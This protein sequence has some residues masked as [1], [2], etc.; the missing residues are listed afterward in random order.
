MKFTDLIMAI[1]T[2]GLL[3]SGWYMSNRAVDGPDWDGRLQGL[4]FSPYHYDQSPIDGYEPSLAQIEADLALLSSR[5]AAVR[6]YSTTGVLREVPRIAGKFG[7][8]VMAGAWI[9]DGPAR[10]SMELD[11]LLA[12]DRE[13]PNVDRLIVGNEAL[14]REE[15]DVPTLISYL[16]RVQTATNTPVSTS[17][18]WHVWIKHPELAAHVDFIAV[19]ILPFWEGVPVDSAL[20]HIMLRYEELR[21]A[22]P[23]KRIVLTEIG[24][25]SDGLQRGQAV[26]SLANQAWLI[27]NFLIEAKIR[28]IDYFVI[29]AFDQPWKEAIESG[30][31]AYWGIYD[32][33]RQPKFSWDQPVR[34]N[35]NWPYYAAVAATLGL[36]LTLALLKR[37]GWLQ[38]GGRLVLLVLAQLVTTAA[39]M[40]AFA[41]DGLY[42]TQF[43]MAV[44]S[45]LGPAAFLLL[46]IVLTEG[47]E[48]S[49]CL[50]LRRRG[51]R[52]SGTPEAMATLPKVSIHVPACNEPPEMLIEVLDALAALDYPDFEVL[53]ID[54]NTRDPALWRPIEAHCALLGERFRFFHLPSWPGFKAGALNFALENTAP[55]AAVIATIDADYIVR[56]DWLSAL[57]YNFADPQVALVQGPQDYRD[58]T[59]TAFKRMCFWEYAGFFHLGM[60]QRDRH[61]A[62]IQHGTMA[63]IRRSA[64]ES[65]GGW[66]EWCIT[67]DA[68]LGLRLFEAGWV[69]R[70]VP[71]SFGRG[72]MPDSLTAYKKQ[73]F[74]WAYGA[75]RILRAHWRS[76]LPFGPSKLTSAQRYNFVAGWLPWIAD[77][78][79]MLFNIMAIAWSVGLVL[80]PNYVEPA[81]PLFLM[82]ALA[83]FAFK[84][85]KTMWLYLV[86]V[87]CGIGG[88]LGA[89]FAGLALSHT[90]AKAVFRGLFTSRLP[91]FRTPKM[92]NRPAFV[93]ALAGAWEETLMM[94][95]LIGAGVYVWQGRGFLEPA[96]LLWVVLLGLQTLPYAAALLLSIVNA[97]GG[98]RKPQRRATPELHLFPDTGRA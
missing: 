19:H 9:G 94:A 30:V 57:V 8:R 12:I 84:V 14:L 73:R 72:L 60:S 29:E 41:F 35:P 53:V 44:L 65:V 58:G 91:F 50:S 21:E 95:M 18:P 76:L 81:L 48:L 78:L 5:A 80:M 59:E 34:D 49:E 86:R 62:I 92:E 46:L 26:P 39:V 70:Y 98:K 69:A 36:A 37:R 96:I 33:D 24:W 87:R 15:I 79:Q 54:N 28:Q 38:G 77:A 13:V 27:R 23:D 17:E 75:M 55:D 10:D 82:A 3:L 32:A 67:E 22:F 93:R 31:G 74:R 97:L 83:L 40:V 51:G 52:G 85:A 16:E 89:A 71:E 66:G 43:D 2:G 61:N 6:T 25:P 7:L 11:A 4:S 45:V 68:E 42:L 47:L 20:E 63:L 56:P 64:L 88:S 1:M 90:V